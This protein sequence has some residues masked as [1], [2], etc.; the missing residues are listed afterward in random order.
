MA[1]IKSSGSALKSEAEEF[2]PLKWGIEKDLM[3]N[4]VWF[5]Q[6]I[7]SDLLRLALG[8]SEPKP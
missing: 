1:K 2:S 8:S 3:E 6:K 7:H 4:P 5:V